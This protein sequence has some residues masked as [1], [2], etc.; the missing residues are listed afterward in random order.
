MWLKSFELEGQFPRHASE[1]PLAAVEYVAQQVKVD[2]VELAAG[3]AFAGRTVEYHRAQIR[4]AL[5]FREATR[6][7][8]LSS[9][10]RRFVFEFSERRPPSA[11]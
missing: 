6:A 2:A 9:P 8:S 5:G 4:T 1:P 7:R 3:Y 10:V 11:C